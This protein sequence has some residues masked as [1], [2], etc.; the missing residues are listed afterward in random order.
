MIVALMSQ[1]NAAEMRADTDDDKP[2]FMAFFD[3]LCVGCRIDQI[4]PVD[5]A[6]PLRSLR[7]YRAYEDELTAPEYLDDLAFD[8]QRDIY[9]DRRCG[10]NGRGIRIHLC[11][12]RHDR[13]CEPYRAG[14]RGGDV[15]KIASDWQ[16]R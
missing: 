2:L 16:V 6:C 11:D 10:G 7:G 8:D 15:E 14:T 3:P 5:C 9:I 4:A 12:E 13:R 1:R